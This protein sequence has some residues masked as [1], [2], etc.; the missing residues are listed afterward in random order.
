MNSLWDRFQKYHL[1]DQDLGI[2]LDVSRVRFSDEWLASMEPAAQKAFAAM[3]ALECGAIANPDE[4]RMVGHYWL[5]A[6]ELAPSDEL[7]EEIVSTYAA[8]RQF[9]VDTH[10]GDSFS[11]VLV[12][13]IGGLTRAL[14]FEL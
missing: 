9:A 10:R 4:G 5:R 14:I 1:A 13:G 7:R 11:D 6:P 12:I 8:I 3:K 2:T